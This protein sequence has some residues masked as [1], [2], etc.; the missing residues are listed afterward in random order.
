MG[1]AAGCPE[2][3]VADAID[4]SFDLPLHRLRDGWCDLR[5]DDRGVRY[6]GAGKPP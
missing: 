5:G 6:F 1:E 3:A 2:L 4:T